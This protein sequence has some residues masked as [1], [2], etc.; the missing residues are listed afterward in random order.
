MQQPAS[1]LA[2]R[3]K[4]KDQEI[5]IEE[6]RQGIIDL[7]YDDE[8][9]FCLVPYIPY[10]WQEQGETISIESGTSKRLNV[11]GDFRKKPYLFR[12]LTQG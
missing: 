10:A 5:L 8:S 3:I 2:Q 11:L 1:L 7:R 4:R 6:D 12:W 9:G